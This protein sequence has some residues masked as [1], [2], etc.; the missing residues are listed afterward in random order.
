MVLTVLLRLAAD[1]EV[2]ILRLCA[3]VFYGR[4]LTEMLGPLMTSTWICC[5]LQIGCL[6]RV[7][8]LQVEFDRIKYIRNKIT[9]FLA[10]AFFSAFS[11]ICCGWFILT[12]ASNHDVY[13]S[14]LSFKP[15]I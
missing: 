2:Q 12:A 13:L 3:G 15:E 9:I 10:S 1:Y 5:F 14:V 11:S 8:R 6:K 4:L 7:L